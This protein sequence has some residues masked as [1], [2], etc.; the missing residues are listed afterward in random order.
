MASDRLPRGISRVD[1]SRNFPRGGYEARYRTPDG[2]ERTQRFSRLIDATSWLDSQRGDKVQGRHVDPHAGRQ[3]F[4]AFADEWA[5]AQDWKETSRETWLSVRKRLERVLG[6]YSLADVD[7]L[8]LQAAQKALSDRYARATVEVSMAFAKSVMKAAYAS[9]RIHRDPT[10]GLKR[11]KLRADG[12]DGRVGPDD[13]PTRAEALALLAAAAPRYRAAIALGIA[14]LRV[15]EVL[16]VSADR[17]EIDRA[18]LTVDRQLQIIG[19]KRTLTTPKAEK[20][21]TIVLPS[22]VTF[23][24]R[25]HLRDFAPDSGMLFRGERSGTLLHRNRF[26]EL[27]WWPALEG[28]GFERGRFVFHSLRH[29]CASTL[30]AEGA[31]LTAVAGHLGDTVATVSRTYIH[32]LRDDRD[33]PAAVLDR[34]LAGADTAPLDDNN[35]HR[36]SN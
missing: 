22:V 14:G 13:V 28:A 21:R 24:L 9:G 20:V 26:Y 8:T 16:A 11:P 5:A 15:G 36:A 33:V 17:V 34:V 30:L 18:T 35:L 2:K 12:D 32:W 4:L 23:E 31:P 3:S 25:R 1:P 19:G 27:A 7:R 10:A 29:F 6:R